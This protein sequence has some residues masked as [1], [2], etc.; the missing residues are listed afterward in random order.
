VLGQLLTVEAE[1]DREVVL[2]CLAGDEHAWE[3]LIDRHAGYVLSVIQRAG[4][5]CGAVLS[6]ADAYDVL[7]DV[8]L[9]LLRD[10]RRLL[11]SYAPQYPFRQWLAMIARARCVDA[12]R[13]KGAVIRLQKREA[14]GPSEHAPTESSQPDESAIREEAHAAVR[15]ALAQLPPRQALIVRLFYL[16]GLKYGEISTLL[17]VPEGTI[18]AVLSRTLAELRKSLADAEL[19]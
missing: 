15:A 5:R 19:Q 17:G 7:Q 14:G 10:D 16:H 2:A 12:L 11:R 6:E 18:G 4:L 13:R 9:Q 1:P 3:V 8:M